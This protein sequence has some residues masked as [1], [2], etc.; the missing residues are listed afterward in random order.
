LMSGFAAV[1]A[2]TACWVSLS[3]ES[4]PQV[5]TRNVAAPPESLSLLWLWPGAHPAAA[6]TQTSK[7]SAVSN[8][9]R[10]GDAARAVLAVALLRA[11]ASAWGPSP[12]DRNWGKVMVVPFKRVGLVVEVGGSSASVVETAKYVAHDRPALSRAVIV[13][14]DSPP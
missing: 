8:R 3:R 6:R 2:S 9:G 4:F 7:R 10:P 11:D 5:E 12:C 1:K 13:S 14:A